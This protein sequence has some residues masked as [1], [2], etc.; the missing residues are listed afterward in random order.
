MTE[1]ET[2]CTFDYYLSGIPVSLAAGYGIQVTF[3]G[4]SVQRMEGTALRFETT[5]DTQLVMPVAQA[6]AV[7]PE[8]SD[9]TLEYQLQD[10]AMQ[11][12]WVSG[13]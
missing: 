4:Q 9:L 6:A 13:R 1:E 10:G 3:S 11:A 2:V 8:G 12:G 7:L 5:G